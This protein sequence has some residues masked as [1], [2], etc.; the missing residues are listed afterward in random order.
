[1]NISNDILLSNPNKFLDKGLL[2][3]IYCQRGI[4][5]KM[6]TQILRALG[7]NVISVKGGYEAYILNNI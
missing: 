1:M 2:Y 6:T 7:Y 5:S 4:T 3:Y